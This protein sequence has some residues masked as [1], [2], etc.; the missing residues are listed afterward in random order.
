ML[1]TKRLSTGTK[2]LGH[3][4]K[5]GQDTDIVLLA[6]SFRVFL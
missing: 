2:A 5:D 3:R 1:E 4:A 6:L